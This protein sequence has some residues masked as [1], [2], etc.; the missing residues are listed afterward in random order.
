MV[1]ASE[2]MVLDLRDTPQEL[3]SLLSIKKL[4]IPESLAGIFANAKRSKRWVG[5]NR[6]QSPDVGTL[7]DLA[8]HL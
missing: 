8:D 3:T 1:C 6:D 7:Q 2:C 4:M 5:L